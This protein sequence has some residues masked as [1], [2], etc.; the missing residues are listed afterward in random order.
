M[1]GLIFILMVVIT[2]TCES[3][4]YPHLCHPSATQ[5]ALRSMVDGAYTTMC[6]AQLNLDPESEA[7]SNWRPNQFPDGIIRGN[8][9]REQ[10]IRLT[11]ESR[12]GSDEDLRSAESFNIG[13]YTW[14]NNKPWGLFGGH[15]H[16]H[17][18][19]HHH[20]FWPPP[21][22]PP[23]WSLAPWGSP[24]AWPPPSFP[25]GWPCC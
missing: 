3:G 12:D 11:T 18:H 22:P 9:R 2:H 16:G 1:I 8:E 23:P 15:K 6:G 20:G 19:Y 25:G 13:I 17:G 24:F 4:T 10:E 14:P 21:P 5:H 7:T